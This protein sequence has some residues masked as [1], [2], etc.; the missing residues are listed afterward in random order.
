VDAFS[1]A[2]T[3]PLLAYNLYTKET[4]SPLGW[5]TLHETNRLGEILQRNLPPGS[6]VFRVS[7]TRE[8]A[9]IE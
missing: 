1:Q 2:L 6:Q 7:M 9:K 8:G 5:K 3:N 4:F